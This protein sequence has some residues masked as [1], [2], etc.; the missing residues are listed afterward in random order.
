MT[1]RKTEYLLDFFVPLTTQLQYRPHIYKI[2]KHFKA[3]RI[4][5]LE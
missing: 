3:T 1:A 4:N 2:Y 5:L